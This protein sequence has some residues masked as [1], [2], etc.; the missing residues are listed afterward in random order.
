[1]NDDVSIANECEDEGEIG[2]VDDFDSLDIDF[3]DTNETNIANKDTFSPSTKETKINDTD[4]TSPKQQGQNHT[5]EGDTALCGSFIHTSK[6]SITVQEKK[7]EI[8]WR[9][10]HK[11]FGELMVKGIKHRD[12]INEIWSQKSIMN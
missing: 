1:M 12:S 8:F 11:L 10:V 5:R 6:N 3:H 9:D 7:Q 2:E 4:D